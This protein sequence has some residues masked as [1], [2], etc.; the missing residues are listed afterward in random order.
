MSYEVL[1]SILRRKPPVPI[2]TSHVPEP[3]RALIPYARFWGI[4]DDLR[5][6]QLVDSARLEITEDLKSAIDSFSAE[7][8]EL[9]TVPE[10][11][12]T[13][14]SHEYAAFSAM[15]MAADYA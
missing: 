3:V 4:P 8:D 12:S 9:L 10:A 5:R 2:R 6:E 7:L 13:Q 14:P 11:R 1:R 15:R